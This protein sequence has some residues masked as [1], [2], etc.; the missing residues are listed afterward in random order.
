L[1]KQKLKKQKQKIQKS[2]K[3]KSV[4]ES[5]PNIREIPKNCKHLVNKDDQLYVVPGDGACGPNCGAAF[6]FEDEVFGPKLRQRMNHFF[7]DHWYQNYQYLTQ[8]SPGYPFRR[9]VKGK[10]EKFT[11][12]EELI[13]YLKS[14]DDAMYMWSD[15]EDFKV[16]ADLYQMR[17]KII[18]TSFSF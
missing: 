16:L 8:C 2:Q 3:K 15:S 9:Q 14:S 12:P 11:D 7:A 10:E 6:L 5:V 13:K 18:T 1:K 17:I 4:I